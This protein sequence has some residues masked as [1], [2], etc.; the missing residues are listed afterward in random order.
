MTSTVVVIV[1]RESYWFVKQKVIWHNVFNIYI[2]IKNNVPRFLNRYTKWFVLKNSIKFID[3]S[4]VL[5]LIIVLYYKH[6][7]RYEDHNKVQNKTKLKHKCSLITLK[8]I[9]ATITLKKMRQRIEWCL[10]RVYQNL[11]AVFLR[12]AVSHYPHLYMSRN[13]TQVDKP[14]HQMGNN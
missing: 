3:Y 11:S 12:Q 9:H 13:Q 6:D 5:L 4:A 2:Y 8:N 7:S 1:Q 14:A 10:V